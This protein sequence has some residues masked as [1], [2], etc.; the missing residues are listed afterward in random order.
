MKATGTGSEVEHVSLD[1]IPPG[2]TL[3][4]VATAAAYVLFAAVLLAGLALLVPTAQPT[5]GSARRPLCARAGHAA[6][7]SQSANVLVRRLVT[8]NT[9]PL[10]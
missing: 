9:F 7:R 5:E 4:L 1:V 10:R 6:E 2:A 8:R 3:G